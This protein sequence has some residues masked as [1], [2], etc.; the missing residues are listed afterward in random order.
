MGFLPTNYKVAM[1]LPNDPIPFEPELWTSCMHEV[2]KTYLSKSTN[3]IK[4]A[5]ARQSPDYDPNL[6]SLF[7]KSQWV[8]KMEKLGAP[9]IKPGQTIASF[10]QQTVMLY[11]T[12]ARYM[13]RMRDVFL[14]KNIRINCE[15]S[16]EDLT[17]WAIGPDAA[18][19]FQG[20][21]LANDFTAFDQSQ[22]GAMLQFEILKAY[23]H[24]IPEEIIQG[25]LDIKL[26]SRIFLGTL[27]IMRLTGE[28][29]TFD[30]NTECNIAFTHSRF[31]I[32]EGAAQLYAGDDSAID[33][34]PIEKPSFRMIADKLTLQSKP[35]VK[36]QSKG[37]WAE[38]CGYW[39]TPKGFIKDPHKLRASLKLEI[40]NKARDKR[41]LQDSIHNYERDL[42]L[43]YRYKDELHEIFTEED[44]EAHYDTVR[45]IVKFGGGKYLN[46][47]LTHNESLY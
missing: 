23:H 22:D 38:F 19:K 11:G 9:K 35:V 24:S 13:R 7:L 42:G 17:E 41:A 47:F 39:I 30:A 4:N 12:M 44:S 29:P 36:M 26:N 18:W 1:K 33:A 27:A 34:L 5:A 25:Y 40:H 37:Q 6:I 16:P 28:G 32:P 20:P 2:Q 10:Q 45:T 15:T 3:M 14:P 31:Q 43:A 46:S 8:K 21:S